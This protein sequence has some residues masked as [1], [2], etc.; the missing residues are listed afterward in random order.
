MKVGELGKAKMCNRHVPLCPGA[1]ETTRGRG[2]RLVT[3]GQGSHG[4]YFTPS[5]PLLGCTLPALSTYLTV[6][7]YVCSSALQSLLSPSV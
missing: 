4:V 5:G 1:P 3:E 7:L 6:R 2:G